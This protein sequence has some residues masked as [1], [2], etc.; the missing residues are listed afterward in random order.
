MGQK[1]AHQL[2]LDEMN[3]RYKQMGIDIHQ[4]KLRVIDELYGVKVGNIITDRDVEY[5][6]TKTDKIFSISSKPF[7][8]AVP[9]KKDGNWS[10]NAVWVNKWELVKRVE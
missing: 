6:I 2:V 10:K 9:R 4:Y 5:K 7:V 1:E 3:Q 8:K